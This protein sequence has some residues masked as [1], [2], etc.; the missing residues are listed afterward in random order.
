[1][2]KKISENSSEKSLHVKEISD[3]VYINLHQITADTIDFEQAIEK[4]FK[5]TDV[6]TGAASTTKKAKNPKTN[7]KT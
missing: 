7:K 1:M 5:E 3:G 4:S 6:K 2:K